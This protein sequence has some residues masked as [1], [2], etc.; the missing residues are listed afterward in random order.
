MKKRVRVRPYQRKTGSVRGHYRGSSSNVKTVSRKAKGSFSEHRYPGGPRGGIS[1][2]QYLDSWGD[3]YGKPVEVWMSPQEFLDAVPPV[4]G[5]YEPS[6]ESIREGVRH[7][8]DIASPWLEVVNNKIVAHEG[9]HRAKVALE[10]NVKKI[11]VIK[12]VKEVEE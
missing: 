6:L 2:E 8:D 5:W 7:G 3:R 9:R 11:P 10:L 12:F 4:P 1:R